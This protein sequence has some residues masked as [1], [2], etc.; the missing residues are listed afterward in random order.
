MVRSEA[1]TVT[2][3]NAV[4]LNYQPCKNGIVIHHFR[5]IN[6]DD[7][8]TDSFSNTQLQFHSQMA[9]SPRRLHCTKILASNF[10]QSSIS[11]T[12]KA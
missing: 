4:I 10:L 2:E 11:V 7:G 3:C 12:C 6:N 1:F 8:G 9:D 5:D